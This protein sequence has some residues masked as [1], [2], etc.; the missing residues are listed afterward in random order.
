MYVN[1]QKDDSQSILTIKLISK[2]C[3]AD[4]LLH[5]N[6]IFSFIHWITLTAIMSIVLFNC[7]GGSFALQ[8]MMDYFSFTLNHVSSM[9]KYRESHFEYEQNIFWSIFCKLNIIRRRAG[10]EVNR[11]KCAFIFSY[12]SFSL[13]PSNS[14][15][16]PWGKQRLQLWY[17]I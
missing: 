1:F 15:F 8:Q 9:F 7:R 13:W 11:N 4:F 3:W 12:F 17:S 5:L 16:P 2:Y 14:C 6:R 10:R